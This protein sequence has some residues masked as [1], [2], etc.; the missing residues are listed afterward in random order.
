[1]RALYDTVTSQQGVL[2]TALMPSVPPEEN[3]RM[4]R[5]YIADDYCMEI[6]TNIY[7]RP[8]MGNERSVRVWN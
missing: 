7:S 8:K 5:S 6:T 4:K 1:M 2:V 3:I